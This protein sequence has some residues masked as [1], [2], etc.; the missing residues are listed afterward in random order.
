M[1][2]IKDWARGALLFAATM[3][4]T[5]LMIILIAS[6]PHHDDFPRRCSLLIGGWHP[7]VSVTYAQR[8]RDRER[9]ALRNSMTTSPR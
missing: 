1:S 6:M 5:V 7:D 9:E 3:V 2:V 8:C 4:G